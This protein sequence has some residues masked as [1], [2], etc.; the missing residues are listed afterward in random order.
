MKKLSL[1]ASALLIS[2]LFTTIAHAD[3]SNAFMP[4]LA[5]DHCRDVPAF[6]FDSSVEKTKYF[7]NRDC[8]AVFLVPPSVGTV[9]VTDP[10]PTTSMG[11][12]PA[13]AAN[14]TTLNTISAKIQALSDLFNKD[15]LDVDT[16]QAKVAKLNE[17]QSKLQGTYTNLA[18]IT[19]KVRFRN[20]LNEEYMAKFFAT[21]RAYLNQ[22][23][24]KMSVLEAPISSS[25]LSFNAII[26]GQTKAYEGNPVLSSNVVGLL[27]NANEKSEARESIRFDGAADG[28][29]VL[30]LNASCPLFTGTDFKDLNTL[31]I[32]KERLS[33]YLVATQTYTVPTLSGFGYNAELKVEDTTRTIF[34]QQGVNSK[35]SAEDVV[36][37]AIK[38]NYENNFTF[39][40]WTYFDSATQEPVTQVSQF[41]SADA[42][43]KI[44]TGMIASYLAKLV[45]LGYLTPAFKPI[46]TPKAG[47][48]TETR[49]RTACTSK[50]FLGVEYD[51][52]C[53]PE[54]YQVNFDRSGH[55]YQYMEVMQGLGS[56]VFVDQVEYLAPVSR[57]FTSGFAVR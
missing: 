56:T 27:S 15:Q 24:T 17:I 18:G 41:I 16:F 54:Y 48:D 43:E 37:A 40:S 9:E 49:S 57:V 38:G 46:E 34:Q 12:C 47:V 36:T 50:T 23:S 21:N 8:T 44:K 4:F 2:Q 11:L 22:R 5:P 33:N 7:F 31:K 51:H 13:V 28:F 53:H 30:N 6:A 19:A 29:V 10:A 20:S 25:Y 32:N 14:V 3:N 45:Q 39:K 1:M 35:F 55:S 52:E 26:P 42:K